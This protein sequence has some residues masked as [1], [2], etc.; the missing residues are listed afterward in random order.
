MTSADADRHRHGAMARTPQA[1][2]TQADVT[3][4][5]S[6][7]P[8]PPLPGHLAAKVSAAIAAESD[9]R[10]IRSKPRPAWHAP[11]IQQWATLPRPRTAN[12]LPSADLLVPVPR[13]AGSLA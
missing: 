6:S 10:V 11:A 7:Q 9:G 4:L 13:G 3:A 2:P 1:A 8:A 12:P 5:L